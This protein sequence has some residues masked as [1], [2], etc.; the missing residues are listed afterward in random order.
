MNINLWRKLP[1]DIFNMYIIPLTRHHQSP[2]LLADIR[3]FVQSFQKVKAYYYHQFI[4]QLGEEE[5]QDANWLIN[6]IGH[7]INRDHP[8]MYGYDAFFFNIW[9]RSFFVQ[10]VLC[11]YTKKNK[12]DW[13]MHF[14]HSEQVDRAN[15][16]YWGILHIREREEF[17]A[18]FIQETIG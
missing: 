14:Y 17:M 7:Y 9:E 12:I 4:V 2:E 5:R 8:M 10:D 18:R 15:H 1:E 3:H 13:I 16:H 11:K 6:D